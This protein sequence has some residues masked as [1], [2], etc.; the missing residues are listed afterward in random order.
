MKL[1]KIEKLKIKYL[2]LVTESESLGLTER[3]DIL[4]IKIFDTIGFFTNLEF[5]SLKKFWW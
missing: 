2:I 5:N 3:S 4:K 1:K